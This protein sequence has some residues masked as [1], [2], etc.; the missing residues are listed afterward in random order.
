MATSIPFLGG[1]PKQNVLVCEA[2]RSM[3]RLLPCAHCGRPPPSQFCHADEGKG[4][5][6]KTDDRRGWPGCAPGLSRTG[7]HHLVGMTGTFSRAQRRQLEEGYAAWARAQV[8]A[9]G[10]WPAAL[11]LWDNRGT[12][13]AGSTPT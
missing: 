12:K 3:V 4:M 8:M 9:A 1:H 13:N 2:Y 6:I 7:C 11:P 5:G 10:H